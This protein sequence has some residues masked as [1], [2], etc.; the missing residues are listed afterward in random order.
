MVGRGRSLVS[1]LRISC[2]IRFADRIILSQYLLSH[3]LCLFLFLFLFSDHLSIQ[4]LPHTSSA[5]YT[6]SCL[7][8]SSQ[9][10]QEH[11]A[12]IVMFC[13]RRIQ[14]VDTPP[15]DNTRLPG[16]S[17]KRGGNLLYFGCT[18]YIGQTRD[19]PKANS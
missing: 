1:F 17:T 5:P 15:Q 10:F 12:E 7:I 6:S 9:R 8:V 13:T 2:D 16:L 4:S 18:L 19:M 14:L 11:L 3:I